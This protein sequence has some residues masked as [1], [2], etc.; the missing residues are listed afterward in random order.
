L[1]AVIFPAF[2]NY[3]GREGLL[4]KHREEAERAAAIGPS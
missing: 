3:D 2:V 1:L 4:R